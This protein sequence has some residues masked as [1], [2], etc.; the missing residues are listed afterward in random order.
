[1]LYYIEITRCCSAVSKIM[2]HPALIWKW[3]SRGRGN[4]VGVL[5][6][7]PYNMDPERWVIQPHPRAQDV[8]VYYRPAGPQGVKEVIPAENLKHLLD[9]MSRL[10]YGEKD[11]RAVRRNLYAKYPPK[12]KN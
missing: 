5:T 10:G 8:I 6:E 4:L 9:I 1:M 7:C 3:V 11:L 2:D 12:A